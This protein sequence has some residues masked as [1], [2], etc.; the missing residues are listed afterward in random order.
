MAGLKKRRVQGR[1]SARAAFEYAGGLRALIDI[2]HQAPA[3]PAGMEAGAGTKRAEMGAGEHLFCLRP[4][5]AGRPV[6][7]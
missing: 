5:L 7:V 4:A 2:V 6:A 1:R 3:R